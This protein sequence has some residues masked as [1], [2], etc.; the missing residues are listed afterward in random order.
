MAINLETKIR[1]TFFL[2][3]LNFIND[4]LHHLAFW[5]QRMQERTALLVDFAD[6]KELIISSFENLKTNYGRDLTLF[7]STVK[8]Q[9]D[10]CKTVEDIYH[11]DLVYYS[12]IHLLSD[13]DDN[14]PYLSDIREIF[15]NAII[16]EIKSFFPTPDLK[17]FKVF[18]P[19]EFPNDISVALTYGVFDVNRICEILKL[20]DCVNLVRDWGKLTVSIIESDNFC[21]FHNSQTE[22]YQFWSHFLNEKGI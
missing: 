19:S 14:V 5:S 18:R 11:D 17:S 2:V 3:I 20:G 16:E 4:V 10:E 13:N 22:T 1:S 6:F 21:K 15:L 8:C 7:L 9:T 12:D